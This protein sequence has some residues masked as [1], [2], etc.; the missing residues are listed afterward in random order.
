[1][2][3]DKIYSDE[4]WEHGVWNEI[5]ERRMRRVKECGMQLRST[6]S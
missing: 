4:K 6:E 1:M 5:Q 3:G 2:R